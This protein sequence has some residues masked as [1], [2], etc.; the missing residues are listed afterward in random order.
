M[1]N[2]RETLNN[3]IMDNN[4][5]PPS[6]LAAQLVENISTST[7]SSRPDETAELQK[8]FAAI[9]KVKNDPD[10]LTS[11]QDRVEHNHMLIYVYARVVLEGLNWDEPFANKSQLRSDAVRAINFLKITV[12]ETPEV[13]LFT[14]NPG[15]FLFRGPES[16][17]IWILPKV[18]RMLGNSACPDLRA[19]IEQFFGEVYSAAARSNNLWSYIPQLLAYL[20]NNFDG[21][22]ISPTRHLQ[23]LTFLKV[24]QSHTAELSSTNKDPPLNLRLP[25]DSLLQSL[26]YN[27]LSHIQEQCTYT[28][29]QVS[30][31]FRHAADLLSLLSIPLRNIQPSFNTPS[32]FQETIPWLMDASL[33][34]HITFS[35]WRK[36]ASSHLPRYLRNT[37]QILSNLKLL[38]NADNLVKEKVYTL[39]VYLCADVL[40][41]RQAAPGLQVAPVVDDALLSIAIVNISE[42]CLSF[43]TVS[44]LAAS[45]IIS[46]IEKPIG[47]DKIATDGTD[48]WVSQVTGSACVFNC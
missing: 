15:T 47:Y 33:R 28:I 13:L 34:T 27:E 5:P 35:R 10:L 30:H 18:L 4:A 9:E 25:Q 39:L 29:G 38:V 14:A 31:A 3:G 1:L 32:S 8:L 41:Q 37:M 46:I 43:A 12:N 21:L 36:V 45:Q 44:H 24:I 20:R 11:P 17:W 22:F 26:G 23:S 6:T 7:R 42:A 40:T 2:G 48:L 19:P 16:L